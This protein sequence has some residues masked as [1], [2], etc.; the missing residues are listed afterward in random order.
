MAQPIQFHNVSTTTCTLD[1]YPG[2]AALNA[3]GVQLAQALRTP[4][5]Y[6][7]GEP[8]GVTSFAVA[9]LHPGTVAAAILEGTDVPV[10]S[11]AS[12][13]CFV[14]PAILVTPP[15]T[16][17]SARLAIQMPSCSRIQVHPVIVG[18]SGQAP[19]A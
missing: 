1:G 3:A 11:T 4:S 14:Y 8:T 19:R 13:A 7:G 2:V 5:G 16:T 18:S 10:G 17:T 12:T 6:M 9:T 15:N